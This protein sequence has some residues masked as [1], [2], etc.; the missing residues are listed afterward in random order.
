MENFKHS[1]WQSNSLRQ[2]RY[3]SLNL[4][5]ENIIKKLNWGKY[6]PRHI[7]TYVY[8]GEY[9]ESLINQL[10][11]YKVNDPRQSWQLK[12]ATEKLPIATERRKSQQKLFDYLKNC[13]FFEI[14]TTP[15]KFKVHLPQPFIQKGVDVL[16]ATDLLSHAYQDNFDVAIICSGDL[17]LI[18]SVKVVKN[19]GK[20]V[21]I[22]SHK[23]KTNSG[24]SKN[25]IKESDYFVNIADFKPDELDEISEI[26]QPEEDAIPS[27][28]W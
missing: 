6:N 9:T 5:C 13:N 24:I 19:L 16:I 3:N 8:T 1:L 7:R 28:A 23:S 18:E 4:L 2:P 12:K 11:Y 17:D 15:L 27:S 21:I 14:K 10:K 22:V 20:K 26:V 25:L